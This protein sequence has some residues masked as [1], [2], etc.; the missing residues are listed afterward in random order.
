MISEILLANTGQTAS[1]ILEEGVLA[2]SAIA[3]AMNNLWEEVLGGGLYF[4]ITRLGVFFAVGTLLLFVVQWAKAMI[5]GDN[6]QSFSEM[7]WPLIVIVLLA[8]NGAVLADGTRGLRNIINET[9]LLLLETTSSTVSL[10]SAYQKVMGEVGAEAAI[11]SVV[12]QCSAIVDPQQQSDCLNNAA[13]QAQEIANSL[14]TPPSSGLSQFI[15]A[16]TNPVE[17]GMKAIS[18]TFQL[19]VRGWLIAFGV[20]FQW[21]TEVSLLLTGLLGPLAVGAS[22]LPV[23]A[24]SIYAWLIGFF[25]VGMVKICFNIITGLV[26]TMVVNADANDP[27]IFAFATGLIAPILSLALAAGG[28]MAVFNSLTS[29]ASFILRKPF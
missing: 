28:G 7:I 1:Q 4:A 18:S 26:A 25:S 11:K 24:K 3:E 17:T 5:D 20:A 12:S 6:P 13:A 9:N 27:M 16:I 23:G 19:A 22:L 8:N 10:Q 29:T 15:Q 2:Q 21:V 14:P